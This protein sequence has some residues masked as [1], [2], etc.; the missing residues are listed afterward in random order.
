MK[1]FLK[2]QSKTKG[3][4]NHSGTLKPD[5]TDSEILAKGKE[6]AI[7]KAFVKSVKYENVHLENISNLDEDLSLPEKGECYKI[8][9]QKRYNAF[10]FLLKIQQHHEVIDELTILT[11]NM[12][13]S[14]L[15][16]L[17]KWID[18]GIVKDLTLCISESVKSRMPKRYE[19]VKDLF[20]HTNHRVAFTWNHCKIA[21]VKCKSDYYVIEGSGNFSNNEEVEQYL[22]E[23]SKE[24]YDFDKYNLVEHLFNVVK[25][26]Q[27]RGEIV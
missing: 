21:L 15:I 19:L 3:V 5:K 7:K 8:R 14:A 11:F 10:T 2:K 20:Q 23:N 16:I 18:T 1:P 27:T 17:K 9:V 25:E 4:K 12:N 24:N 13:E 6:G 26:R 22:F